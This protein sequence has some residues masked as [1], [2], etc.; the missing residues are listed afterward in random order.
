MIILRSCS[1]FSTLSSKRYNVNKMYFICSI[2]TPLL[3]PERSH[4][5][6]TMHVLTREKSDTVQKRYRTASLHATGPIQH[7]NTQSNIVQTGSKVDKVSIISLFVPKKSRKH[8]IRRSKKDRVD[9]FLGWVTALLA[10]PL[11]PSHFVT[12]LPN[13]LLPRRVIGE[14][15]LTSPWSDVLFA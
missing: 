7:Y 5:C 15:F 2:L 9:D 4:H 13:P 1:L 14:V 8:L 11:P 10:D 12:F 3:L 6:L